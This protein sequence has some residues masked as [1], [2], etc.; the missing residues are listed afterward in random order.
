MLYIPIVIYVPAL[1]FSQVSGFSLYIIVPIIC[2]VCIFYTT[3]VK[4]KFLINIKFKYKYIIKKKKIKLNSQG[5]IKAVVWTDTL[6]MILMIFG[7]LTVAIMGTRE[8]GGVNNVWKRN[9]E[10][11][12]IDFFK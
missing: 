8:V 7:V 12:R 2:I 9:E 10:S 4:I 3:L 1:A 5:G 6:Q 11:G